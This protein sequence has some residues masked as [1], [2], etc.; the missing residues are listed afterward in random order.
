MHSS[1]H[2]PSPF[3]MPPGAPARITPRHP[4]RSDNTTHGPQVNEHNLQLG[5]DVQVLT[6]CKQQSPGNNRASTRLSTYSMAPT[7]TPS[8]APSHLSCDYSSHDGRPSKS[9]KAG[10]G[11]GPSSSRNRHSTYSTYS[12]YS[13]QSHRSD[14][15]TASLTPSELASPLAPLV[16]DIGVL[17]AGLARLDQPKLQDQRYAVSEGKREEIGKLALGA[18]LERALGRRMVGQDASFTRRSEKRAKSVPLMVGGPVGGVPA[19][20]MGEKEI[21]A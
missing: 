11:D 6:S 3:L 4:R 5:A 21:V 20:R 8:I 7:L 9:A 15:T 12:T 18:K 19:G 2:P 14:R 16:R 10:A 17:S 1:L 13:Q